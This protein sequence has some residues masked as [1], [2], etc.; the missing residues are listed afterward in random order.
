MRRPLVSPG[1]NS[2]S[3]RFIVLYLALSVAAAIPVFYF[4]YHSTDR[5]VLE[6]IRSV[7]ADETSLLLAEARTGGQ[8]LVKHQIDERVSSGAASHSA[9]LLVDREGRRLAG[10]IDAWPPTVKASSDWTE[11][12]LF[13]TGH[14]APE[15]VGLRATLL[16]GGERLL[17]GRVM[18]DRSRL[19]GALALALGAALLIAIPLALL[20]SF[21]LLRFINARVGSI[22][23]AAAAFAGGDLERRVP[24][25][26][27][28]DPFDQLGASLNATFNRLARLVE[29]LRFVTDALAH[30]L[31]SPLTRIQAAIDRGLRSDDPQAARAALDSATAAIEA[32]LRML[33]GTLE[34]SRAEAGIGRESFA[35]VDLRALALDLC[36]M[37]QP[38]AEEK[39][40]PIE[41]SPAESAV[42]PGNRELLGQA[43]A[44]LVDNAL[45]YAGDGSRISIGVTGTQETVRL[46]V[47][48][49][50]RGIAQEQRA[51][52]VRKY[53]RLDPAR[54]SDGS[55]LGL[56]LVRAI[57]R[58]HGGDLLLED[59]EPGLRAAL[60]LPRSR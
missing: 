32:M 18:D 38:L 54:S 5:L 42:V 50:G 24:E 19:R 41:V 16:P 58:L 51:D 8:A 12:L 22:G 35:P 30:D 29:E 45:K 49:N 37:Y 57:A 23:A 25:S 40:M 39:G 17:V 46:W 34:V 48:D 15:P 27:S 55:G 20:G 9:F 10:N 14:S 44:N 11:M 3:L 4:I 53:R 43:V 13:R 26:G 2:T 28:G 1:R 52:A 21:A 47:A 31:R 7:V 56:A 36:E 60:L 59:N 33:N 6:E